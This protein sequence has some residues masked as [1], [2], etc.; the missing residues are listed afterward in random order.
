MLELLTS[1]TD[2]SLL[3]VEEAGGEASFHRLETIR[4]Y[5]LEKLLE[6]GEIEAMRNRHLDFFVDLA[7]RANRS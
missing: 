2:K 3:F 6:T 1:L 7:E 4:Q 5:A